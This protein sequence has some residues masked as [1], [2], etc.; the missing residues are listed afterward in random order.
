MFFMFQ[1]E[2]TSLSLLKTVKADTNVRRFRTALNYKYFKT[3]VKSL[4]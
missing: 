2:L 4:K 3:R 1:N